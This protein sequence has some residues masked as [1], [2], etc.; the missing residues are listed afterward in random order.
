M[1]AVNTM[2][3]PKGGQH[4]CRARAVAIANVAVVIRISPPVQWKRANAIS[5]GVPVRRRVEVPDRRKADRERDE[6]EQRAI[7][8][9]T[10]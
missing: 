5:L 9:F 4:N 8:G 1:I 2:R 6:W 7:G 3:Q 10:S